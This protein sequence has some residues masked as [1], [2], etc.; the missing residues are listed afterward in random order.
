[1]FLIS[2]LFVFTIIYAVSA[3][4]SEAVFTSDA[5]RRLPLAVRVGFGYFL[6]LLYF[7]SAWLF[8]SIR[9]AWMLG[10]VLLALYVYGK[11]AKGLLVIKLGDAKNLLKKHLCVLAAFLLVA[12]FFFLPLHLAANYGPFSEGGGDVT[13]Y[14]DVAK[15]LA[16]FNLTATGLE[17]SASIREKFIYI[18]HLINK[19]FSEKYKSFSPSMTDPPNADYESNIIGFNLQLNTIQYTPCAQYAFLSGDTNYP[20]YFA[21][22]AFLY[23][24]ILTSVWGFFRRYGLIAAALAVLLVAGSHSLISAFY[25]MYFLQA[26]ST[27]GLALILAAVPFIRLFS[28][29]G[30]KTY[31]IVSA[32]VWISYSHFMPLIL[33]LMVIAALTLFY[34]RS[35]YL[36][37]SGV[38]NNKTSWLATLSHI[39]AWCVFMSFCLSSIYIGLS[40]S[41]HFITSLL[42]GYFA[43]IPMSGANTYMGDRVSEFSDRWFVSIFGMASQQHF[44]PYAIESPLVNKLIPWGVLTGLLVIVT[45]FVL[46]LFFK[47][48][49]VL[50]KQKSM[51]IW[52]FLAVYF[53]L[54][55]TVVAFSMVTQMS[56]YTQAKS[57]QYL[58]LCVY[59]IMLLPLALLSQQNNTSE[60]ASN[61]FDRGEP[62]WIFIFKSVY[63]CILLCFAIFLWIPRM[64]Y[65]NKLAH[66][67]DRGSIMESSFF[68]E[69]KKIKAEDS[70]AFVLFEP[71]KSTDAYFGHQ[72]FAGY[73]MVPTR[74]LVLTTY[75]KGNDPGSGYHTNHLPSDFIKPDDLPNLW[76]LAA[77][78][79]KGYQ[80]KAERL[81]NRKSPN[82]YFTGY[83]YQQDFGIERDF[84]I[85]PRSNRYS[86]SPS[87]PQSNGE[88]RFSYVRN[89]TAMIYLPP[90]GPH[91]LE[92][93]ILNRDEG[94]FK[95]FNSLADEI[96]E[97]VSSYEFGSIIFMDKRKHIITLYYY[98]QSS[99]VPRLSLVAKSSSEYWFNARLDG[100]EIVQEQIVE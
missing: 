28:L 30:L 99:D 39:A 66:Q 57:A 67:E 83:D 56:Q 81:I 7:V 70:N 74:H 37:K 82:L 8:M 21:I 86:V 15:R 77:I 63:V 85:R 51:E 65:V 22:L 95:E 33:P 75:V 12:N 78:R 59:F 25:N 29:A 88:G 43:G 92:V 31:W 9:Q 68:S 80:W 98:F 87:D 89:G 72:S 23:G 96:A 4:L 73:R 60:Y 44:Q 90:G 1:M 3:I 69:A 26:I 18:D 100:K 71:R 14:S 41:I 53:A 20:A 91:H 19:R 76:S 2:T 52:H 54:I 36:D 61:I 50:T 42:E 84:G 17:E 64:V 79:K 5:E 6:S 34:P 35:P 48:R 93:K 45:S 62:N 16:D 55:I 32:C 58:L 94:N 40:G 10:I 97:K 24:C 13:V 38:S 27:T 47:F 11:F 49:V 46:V